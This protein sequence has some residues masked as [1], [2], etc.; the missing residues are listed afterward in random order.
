[1]ATVLTS[2]NLSP[3]RDCFIRLVIEQNASLPFCMLKAI[4]CPVVVS[5]KDILTML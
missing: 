3:G 1:M 4:L 2:A 5:V